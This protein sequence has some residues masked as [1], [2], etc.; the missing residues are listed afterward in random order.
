MNGSQIIKGVAALCVAANAV[1]C[2]CFL[3]CNQD[4]VV[5]GNPD[6]ASIVIHGEGSMRSGEAYH[7][8]RDKSY[9][10]TIRRE[11]YQDEHF[12]VESHLNALGVLD[13]VGGCCWLVPFIG[14]ASPGSHDLSRDHYFYSLKPVEQATNNPNGH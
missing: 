1:G 12:H 7:L 2:S 8:R 5:S 9:Y 6:D 4:F 10:G 14:L 3:P 13:I 11:G